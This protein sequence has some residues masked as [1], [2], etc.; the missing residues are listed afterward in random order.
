[1]PR[2]ESVPLPDLLTLLRETF[3]A[4]TITPVEAKN[5]YDGNFRI[6]DHLL[7]VRLSARRSAFM[8]VIGWGVVLNAPDAPYPAS[9]CITRGR[10][11][12]S[13]VRA[14]RSQ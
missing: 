5:W 11:G 13:N 1:M 8:D 2:R 3:P 9:I 6:G 12:A 7:V 10:G 4:E 14:G